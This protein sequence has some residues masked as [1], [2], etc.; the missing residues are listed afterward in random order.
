MGTTPSKMGP[1]AFDCILEESKRGEICHLLGM[2]SK[3]NLISN[4][5]DIGDVGT[6]WVLSSLGGLTRIMFGSTIAREKST[7]LLRRNALLDC[8]CL[9]RFYLFETS[10]R[11]MIVRCT[12]TL[13]DT[14]GSMIIPGT[15]KAPRRSLED[16]ALD[17]L[18]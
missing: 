14:P 13:R 3:L 11:S 6:S 4:I 2:E 15:T 9:T 8:W 16:V 17:V 10:R 5:R 7:S 1:D 12:V 18:S